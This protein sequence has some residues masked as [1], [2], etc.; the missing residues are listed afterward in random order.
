MSCQSCANFSSLSKYYV[1]D[2]KLSKFVLPWLISSSAL[3]TCLSFLG[4]IESRLSV[5]EFELQLLTSTIR[6]EE[7]RVSKKLKEYKLRILPNSGSHLKLDFLLNLADTL[8]VAC[9]SMSIVS[10]FKYWKG[11]T[12]NCRRFLEALQCCICFIAVG[13]IWGRTRRTILSANILSIRVDQYQ[14]FVIN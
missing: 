4:W 2:L 6:F 8:W 5:A 3:L 13:G 12:P 11:T 14:I 1:I 7:K 9:V 10:N